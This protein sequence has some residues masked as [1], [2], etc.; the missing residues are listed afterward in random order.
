MQQNQIIKM[1]DFSNYQIN[2]IRMLERLCKIYDKS[3]LRVGIESLKEIDGDQAFLCQHVDQLIGFLSWYSSDG[4]EANINSMVH[5]EFRRSG[6]FRG[7]LKRATSE[8][9][10]HGILTCRFRIPSNSESGIDCIRHLGASFS[11]SE[12]SMT[13]KGIEDS[14][15]CFTDVNL[16]VA[17][18]QDLE[19]LIKCLSQA[20]GDLESWTRKY[21]SHTEEPS[22]ITYIATDSLTPVGMIRV[23]YFHTNTAIIHDF[24]VLPAF[25]GRGYGREILS[26]V[27]K[28]L[29][30]QEYSQIRLSVVTQNRRALNLYQSIGFDVSAE[31]LYYVI[32]IHN[33]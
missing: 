26:R 30:S 8:M 21:L 32:P 11:S 18:E 17:E 9:Q 10:M 2:Q 31:S 24:C 25:Q 19:F 1:N 7:L 27:V 5:P 12:F 16:R 23:N 3:S 29:Q 20:F 22:R 15:L 13:F 14:K 28:L 4:I 33:I 6:I